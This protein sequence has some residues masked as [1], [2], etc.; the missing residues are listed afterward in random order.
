MFIPR[1]VSRPNDVT[2]RLVSTRPEFVHEFTVL[3][4]DIKGKGK[5]VD[6]SSAASEELAALVHLALSNH[7]VWISPGLI[8]PDDGCTYSGQAIQYQSLELIAVPQTYPWF[9][10]SVSPRVSRI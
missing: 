5:T 10:S 7:S 6:A 4:E 1:K 3:Q 2:R 9:A 8:S